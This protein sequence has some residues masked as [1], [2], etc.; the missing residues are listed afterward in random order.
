MENLWKSDVSFRAFE[1]CGKFRKHDNPGKSA[2]LRRCR[3]GNFAVRHLYHL[4]LQWRKSQKRSAVF[5]V[6]FLS[7]LPGTSADSGDIEENRL[8]IKWKKRME[9]LEG[10]VL[11]L[12]VHC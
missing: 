9:V 6:V 7:F 12:L 2:P 10:S 11:P 5:Q 1:F 4:F 3:N 8:L